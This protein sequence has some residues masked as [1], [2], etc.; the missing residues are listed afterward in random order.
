V[1]TGLGRWLADRPSAIRM[2]GLAGS[3][4]LGIDA[5]LFGAGRVIRLHVDP[6]TVATGPN[7]IAIMTLWIV[8]TAALA[9]AWWIGRR[10]AGRVTARWAT[11]TAAIWMLPMLVIPPISSRDVYAYSCQ[12]ALYAAGSDPYH[13]GV[14]SLPCQWLDS[15]SAVW[16]DT[17]TPYGP[18][19]IMTAGGFSKL[20]SLTAAIIAFRLLAVVGV[21]L[22]ALS[23]PP[24]ARHFGLPVE[25]S[26]WLILACPL[27]VI[28][29]VG[30]A[31]NDA[32][33][34]GLLLAALAV[35]ASRY[36]RISGLVIGGALIGMSVAIKPTILVAVPFVALYAAGGA[37]A[38]S[39]SGVAHGGLHHGDARDTHPFAGSSSGPGPLGFPPLGDLMRRGGAVLGSAF[40]ALL[41]VT[42]ISGLGFGWISALMHAGG[43]PSW[44]SPSTS[45]GTSLNALLHRFGVHWNLVPGTRGAGLV[46]LPAALALIFWR[47]R[48][49]DRFYGAGIALLAVTFFAPIA[50]P[51]YLVWPLVMLSLTRA[52]ARWFGI[53]VVVAGY[54]AMTN[55]VGLDGL[56]RLTLSIGMSVIAVC[57]LVAGVAWL[58]GREPAQDEAVA[59]EAPAAPMECATPV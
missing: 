11:W 58:G 8:G 15:V 14:S 55:G 25:R 17:P 3:V 34:I 35:I 59:V 21:V 33:T 32:I 43:E 28:H 52:R 1:A 27:V 45:V 22:I 44:T 16:R 29:L 10:L 18:V 53:A 48:W 41:I 2:L 30:G 4:M 46:L 49:A 26:M 38:P 40:V 47:A 13:Q 31:H 9:G 23:V 54:A 19:F 12:G 57:A 36:E 42:L 20:G 50:Q 6:Q 5:Y 39:I 51:W 37:D 7:G 24:I 56:S